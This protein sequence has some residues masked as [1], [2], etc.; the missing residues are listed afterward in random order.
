ML[1]ASLFNMIICNINHFVFRSKNMIIPILHKDTNFINRS[2]EDIHVNKMSPSL[3]E[4]M[5]ISPSMVLSPSPG[6]TD[7]LGQFVCDINKSI[8]F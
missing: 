5:D 6:K 1:Y 3:P 7:W 4:T 2:V 8:Y